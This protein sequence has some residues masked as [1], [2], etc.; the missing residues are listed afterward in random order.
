M[1]A[2]PGR[3][4]ILFAISALGEAAGLGPDGAAGGSRRRGVQLRGELAAGRDG[5]VRLAVSVTPATAAPTA[6]ASPTPTPTATASPSPTPTA[7]PAAAI[8]WTAAGS[9]VRAAGKPHA[10]LADDGQSS[11]PAASTRRRALR[12]VRRIWT[13]TGAMSKPRSSHTAT[14]LADGRVLVTGGSGRL[15]LPIAS[16]ELFDA[17]DGT[18][19]T[20]EPM[21]ETRA[22]HTAT[23]LLDGRV[24]VTGGAIDPDG[25]RRCL[26]RDLRSDDR[27]VGRRRSLATAA[28]RTRRR[29]SSMAASW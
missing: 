28:P 17:R 5:P 6:T 16:A 18:W 1:R 14:L 15:G 11:S 22:L 13:A 29:S 21:T 19:S 7:T 4:I 23:L 20:T 9:L 12:P 3:S 24:L 25:Q 26:D 8:A 27:V 2:R 10:D